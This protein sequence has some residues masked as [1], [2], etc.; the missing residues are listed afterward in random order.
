MEKCNCKSSSLDKEIHDYINN[1]LTLEH[2][3][4]YLIAILHKIQ[5]R[6]GYLSEANMDEVAHLLGVPTANVSGVATFYH[7]FRLKPR[8]HYSI[9][10]CLGTACFVKGADQVLSAFMT[11]LGIGIGETTADGVFSIEAARCIGVCALA[12]VVMINNEVLSLTAGQVPQLLT[13]LRIK[14]NDEKKSVA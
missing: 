7:Y 2:P 3:E 9:S 14:Y 13:K 1:C 8:G 12:P 6:Y 4:S 10:I 5:E 11:E